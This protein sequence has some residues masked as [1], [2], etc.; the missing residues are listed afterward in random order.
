MIRQLCEDDEYLIVPAL[1]RAIAAR[2]AGQKS[3]LT[4][5]PD[6]R[7]I[8]ATVLETGR[9]DRGFTLI[10][11]EQI[12]LVF[13]M[14]SP[15]WDP[16][17]TYCQHLLSLR[18]RPGRG[19]GLALAYL[20]QVARFYKAEYIEHS[21]ELAAEDGELRPKLVQAGFT[22]HGTNHIKHLTEAP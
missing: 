18:F 4:N 16:K 21:T 6:A 17:R 15:W 19:Y 20:E 5:P 1:E 8:F 13:R 3:T 9:D 2:N 22:P 7:S 10:V 14:D 12:L 11:D